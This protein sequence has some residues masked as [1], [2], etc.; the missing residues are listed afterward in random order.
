MTIEKCSTIDDNNESKY[1]LLKTGM[2]LVE[3]MKEG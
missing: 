3:E 2:G 1:K